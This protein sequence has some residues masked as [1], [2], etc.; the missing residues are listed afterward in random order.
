MERKLL[1]LGLLRRQEMHGY[2][3]YEFIERDL[4]ICTDLKKPTAYYLLDKMAQD[5]WIG[6]EQVQ[7]GNRPP[8]KVYHLTDTGEIVFQELLRA[9]LS[10]YQP[11]RFSG[12]SG[13]AFLDELPA[14]D[15]SAC[16]YQRRQA[17]SDELLAAQSIPE[18]GGSAQ[19]AL[20]HQVHHLESELVWIDEVLA[21]L[22]GRS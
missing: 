15:A 13:L 9:N 22:E 4:A 5:G 11:V 14:A 7:E 17:I 3:L 6:E 21:G 1:L 12:D 16:L 20:R 18:H 19:L 10:S 8:R 2:Q